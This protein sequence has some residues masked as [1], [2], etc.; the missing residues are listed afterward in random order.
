MLPLTKLTVLSL[1]S[2]LLQGVTAVVLDA[3]G[4]GGWGEAAG[5]WQPE[6]RSLLPGKVVLLLPPAGERW[7]SWG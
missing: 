2:V 3:R 5:P 1:E 7:L 4:G 6:P